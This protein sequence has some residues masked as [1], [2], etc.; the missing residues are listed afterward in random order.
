ML[1]ITEQY[2]LL[3]GTLRDYL[4]RPPSCLKNI[5]N[6]GNRGLNVEFVKE[7]VL[8]LVKIRSRPVFKVLK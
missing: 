3:S 7:E 6:S 1:Y 4:S 5:A 8:H 2:A